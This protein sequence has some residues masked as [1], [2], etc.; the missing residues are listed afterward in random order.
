MSIA[1][2]A[3][4][5]AFIVS[6]TYQLGRGV[7]AT[8]AKNGSVPPP[9]ACVAGISKLEAA[10]DRGLA[11]ASGATDEGAALSAFGAEAQPEWNDL[12]ATQAACDPTPTGK[13]AY[14]ALLRLRMAD[15]SFL[16]R[17]VADLS[18]IRRDVDAYLR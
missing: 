1:F 18:P 4:A 13:D 3:F 12:P 10:L 8:T 17:R 9:P 7:F 14:A 15:E 2:L 16:K 5:A 6:S 11:K